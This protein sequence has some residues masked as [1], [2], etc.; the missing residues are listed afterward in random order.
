MNKLKQNHFKVYAKFEYNRILQQHF[1]ALII[2]LLRMIVSLSIW[3]VM[4]PLTSILHIMGYRRVTVFT[5]RI[6]HLA[7]EPDCLFK[8]VALG[9]I[10]DRRFFILAPEDR[11]ANRHLLT[12]WAQKITCY[13]NKT[14]CF[15]LNSMS[16]WKLMQ[17]DVSHFISSVDKTPLVYHIN[18]KWGDRSPLIS[19]SKEDEQWG[20]EQ[21][22]QMGM[23]D[24]CWFVCVHARESGFS[25][26]DEQI[27][28]HRN[29]K[30]SNM[31]PAM[32]EITKRGG[33]VVRIGDKTM[34]PLSPMSQVVDYALH[35]MKS[36]RLDIILCA[37]AKFTLGNSSGIAL[38][39]TIFGVPCAISN[40][41]PVFDLWFTSNDISIPK[42]IWS[43]K[44][45]CHLSFSELI[46]SPVSTYR[47]A[48]L[49]AQE[50]LRVDENDEEDILGLVV[51][52]LERL[53]G[54]LHESDAD[55]ILKKRY[56]RLYQNGSSSERSSAQIAIS[57][58]RKNDGLLI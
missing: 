21:M 3:F 36:N 46:N 7:I 9:M 40:M 17:Y 11:V 51:E 39:S 42:Y 44:A 55:T 31:I 43:D 19:L 58:L 32:E 18:S 8:A 16:R 47:Y 33:W 56:R 50:R 30:I 57:F 48:I 1:L 26:I 25:L 6:G 10:P 52:M 4:L 23:P 13:E 22:K 2:K 41:I 35:S 37:K 20:K 53:S 34:K 24:N 28:A 15:V 29:C 12:Y 54:Q 27:Q 45:G 49:Y 14:L 5:D 38:V